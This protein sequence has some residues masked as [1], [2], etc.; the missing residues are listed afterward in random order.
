MA[1]LSARS[2]RLYL[3]IMS[4]LLTAFLVTPMKYHRAQLA[5]EKGEE[6]LAREALK[7]R[8]S[9]A[10]NANALRAQLDQQKT[11]VDNLVSNT[12]NIPMMKVPFQR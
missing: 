5:L 12:R 4:M 2:N 11:V 8:K 3:V 10:D 9:F 7:R 1:E 6:D